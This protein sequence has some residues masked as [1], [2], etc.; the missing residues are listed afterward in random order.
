MVLPDALV[1][2]C[3]IDEW[4]D[5]TTKLVIALWR[6]PGATIPELQGRLGWARATVYRAADA[7]IRS[8][9][10]E[11]QGA[12]GKPTILHPLAER[13]PVSDVRHPVQQGFDLAAQVALP[14]GRRRPTFHSP[15]EVQVDDDVQRALARYPDIREEEW[16][17]LWTGLMSMRINGHIARGSV[18][19][20]L[21]SLSKHSPSAVGKGMCKWIE[22]DCAAHGKGE[23]YLYAIVRNI[24]DEEG[25]YARTGKDDRGDGRKAQGVKR[26]PNEE[27]IWQVAQRTS[28]RS[29]R[30]KLDG[31]GD[32]DGGVR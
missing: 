30:A 7:L 19:E 15:Q 2:Q 32:G 16:I 10:V 28:L 14:S 23:R 22:R 27:R 17:A 21:G 20:F 25:R 5:A 26:Q 11:T 24:A 3:L 1:E 31:K 6:W 29:L 9:W 18:L 13:L 8:G 12:E 4:P